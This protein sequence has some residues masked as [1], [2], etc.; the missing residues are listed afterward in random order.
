MIKICFIVFFLLLP[1]S[2]FSTA[3][4]NEN[5]N[6]YTING[7]T[8]SELRKV[9]S[10]RGPLIDGKHFDA[11]VSWHINWYYYW[12]ENS[13]QNN[14]KISQVT[15]KLKLARSMPQCENTESADPKLQKL[16]ANYLKHLALHEQGHADNGLKAAQEIEETLLQTP[17]QPS[18]KQL[19]KLLD[20]QAY[21]II[22]KHNQWDSTYDSTTHHGQTQGAIFP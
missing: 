8:S 2:G 14:C 15:I 9:M 21:A 11:Q 20:A 17:A 10:E 4:I 5:Y 3:L 6:Y 19:K 22:K 1:V 13:G 18:C 12:K 16:W 7:S